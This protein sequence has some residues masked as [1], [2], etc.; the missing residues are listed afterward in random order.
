MGTGPG[1]AAHSMQLS[2]NEAKLI[3]G[4]IL[5]DYESERATTIEVLKAIPVGKEGYTPDLKSMS[6]LRLAFHIAASEWYFLEAIHQGSPPATH[7]ELPGSV[8]TAKD[9]IAWENERIP[10]QIENVKSLSGEALSRLI[11]F[12]EN[13]KVA[14]YSLLHLMLKHSVHHRGQLSVYLRPMGAAVP[15]IYGPSADTKVR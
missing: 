4:V 8:H 13:R 3:A 14:G 7:P 2:H 15:S 10:A 6:A 5:A 1:R 9:V 11:A 12:G